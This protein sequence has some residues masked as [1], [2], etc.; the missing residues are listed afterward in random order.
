MM[1]NAG[2]KTF[3]YSFVF[4]LFAVLT[5]NGLYLRSTKNKS[6]DIKI[7][8]KNIALFLKNEAPSSFSTTPIKKIS[9]SEPLEEK[10]VVLADI[11][12]PPAQSPPEEAAKTN[13]PVL[14]APEEEIITP[15]FAEI[16]TGPAVHSDLPE[17]VVYEGEI[18][19]VVYDEEPAPAAEFD[20]ASV[21]KEV[22][23]KESELEAKK[24]KES[25]LIPLQKEFG[26]EQANAA[27]I[28]AFEDIDSNKVAANGNK[29]LIKTVAAEKEVSSEKEEKTKTT[30][31]WENMS[32]KKEDNPWAAAKGTNFPKNKKIL[33]EDFFQNADA[34][35]IAQ[36]LGKKQPTKEKEVLLAADI[37]KNIL[38]P[39]PEEIMKEENL[40]P[41]L[42]SSH[43]KDGSEELSPEQ[44]AAEEIGEGIEENGEKQ[45]G[46]L[47][48]ISSMF[49]KA[50]KVDAADGGEKKSGFFE[51][52]TTRKNKAKEK[53]KILPTEMRLSFQP[54]R[55]E[56]SGQTLKWLQAFANK[57]IEDDS[58]FLEIRIDGTSSF[59]LQ[60]KRLNLLHN[61]LTNKGVSYN[62]I[63]TIFTTREPNS[64]IVRAVR[65][66]KKD[67]EDTEQ[68]EQ[69]PYYYQQW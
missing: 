38:I 1:K 48:S 4:S 69:N 17:K 11:S 39:I 44:K 52:L 26:A 18:F 35:N 64:F 15:K 58:V 31:P 60:Q 45:G 59:E 3:V 50:P 2:L 43:K 13:A 62:K 9:L 21:K 29:A 24:P 63:N 7:P 28:R 40:T 16:I 53:T 27:V 68:R 57:A 55:A 54:N 19:D 56:I 25:L 22:I 23:K 51:Q 5:A 14:Y 33:N 49:S 10:P 6:Y 65:I 67:N 46:I 41:Q 66:N 36:T 61:I 37:A 32:E 20:I 34:D 30:A 12:E 47:K 8:E 42:I